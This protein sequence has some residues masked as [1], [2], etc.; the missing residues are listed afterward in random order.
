MD[1]FVWDR[2]LI[3][4]LQKKA[5]FPE[6]KIFLANTNSVKSRKSDRSKSFY[7]LKSNTKKTK[8]KTI[9]IR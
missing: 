5:K 1:S 3:G 6:T 7:G 8:T 4:C 9:L 2:F